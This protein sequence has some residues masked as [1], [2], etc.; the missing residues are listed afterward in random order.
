M[1]FR[2]RI[3]LSSDTSLLSMPLSLP[4]SL[5]PFLYYILLSDPVRS[6]HSFLA[7]PGSFSASPLAPPP[8]RFTSSPPQAGILRSIC[9]INTIY[10]DLKD[11]PLILSYYWNNTRSRLM[12][13]NRSATP[14]GPR[15]GRKP[16]AGDLPHSTLWRA[17]CP[18]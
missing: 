11:V 5:S 15:K 7:P 17:P 18:D 12:R 8:R 1:L 2:F 3:S 10:G 13:H 6:L 9:S 16:T 14:S 4:V